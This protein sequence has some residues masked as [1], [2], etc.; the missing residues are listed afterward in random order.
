[1]DLLSPPPSIAPFGLSAL[2]MIAR[3]AKGGMVGTHQALFN[4]TITWFW[5]SLFLIL[6]RMFLCGRRE[7][8]IPNVYVLPVAA[9]FDPRFIGLTECFFD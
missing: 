3:A 9:N 6:D 2:T 1:M 4:A 7:P 5:C 8:L